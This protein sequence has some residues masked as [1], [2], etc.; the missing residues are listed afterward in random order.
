MR[1]VR[2]KDHNTKI[3]LVDVVKAKRSSCQL[4]LYRYFSETIIQ[5]SF[6]EVAEKTSLCIAL[7]IL[8]S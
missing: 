7:K 4:L 5:Q 1:F 2:N 6:F 3:Y 8:L